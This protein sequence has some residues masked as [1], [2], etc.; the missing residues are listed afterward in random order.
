M[1]RFVYIRQSC[2]ISVFTLQ[3]LHCFL[4][5]SCDMLLVEQLSDFLDQLR[6]VAEN[7]ESLL[8]SPYVLWDGQEHDTAP[9]GRNPSDVRSGVAPEE[10]F[11]RGTAG[12]SLQRSGSGVCLDHV[13]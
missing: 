8:D 1:S 12:G 4:P 10:L 11:T 7:G 13:L 3:L 5:P 2:P 6:S 9:F